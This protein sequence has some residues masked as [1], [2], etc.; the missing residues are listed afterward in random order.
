MQQQMLARR[1]SR[2][3][4]LAAPQ[5][6]AGERSF[7]KDWVASLPRDFPDSSS[8][9][10]I[11]FFSCE[12]LDLLCCIGNY[13]DVLHRAA[14]SSPL[15]ATQESPCAAQEIPMNWSEDELGLLEYPPIHQQSIV[16]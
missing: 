11:F 16:C 12:L 4:F 1:Q 10:W 2:T 5:A 14:N 6:K 3:W 15:L 13:G 8:A 9:K 7:L